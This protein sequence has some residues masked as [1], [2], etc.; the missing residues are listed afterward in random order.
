M[1]KIAIYGFLSFVFCFSVKGQVPSDY[2]VGTWYGFKN[3]AVSYTFDDYT[4]NQL[5]VAMSLFDKYGFKMTFFPIISWNPDWQKLN[6]AAKNGHEV[7]SHTVTHPNLAEI[8][9]TAV[10]RHEIQGSQRFINEKVSAQ[11]CL[12]IAYP[13]CAANTDVKN[14]V[15]E[16]Y[17]GARI[18]S[19]QIEPATPADFMAVSSIS[20]GELGL[21]TAQT[22]NDKTDEAALKN[23]WCVFLFHGVNHDGGYSPIEESVLNEHLNHVKTLDYWVATFG[24]VIKY[25]KERDAIKISELQKTKTKIVMTASVGSLN[26]DIYNV[27]VSVKRLLPPGWKNVKITTHDQVVVSTIE[28]RNGKMYVCFDVVPDGQ[29][30]VITKK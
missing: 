1:K 13:Y 17:I 7:G 8:T 10:C 21:N 30:L 24:H 27:P 29:E 11:H 12:T 26:S 5:P 3:A 22:L 2:Q 23:G 19:G 18:C 15:A 16:T 28:K 4:P 14:M 9:D 20:C 6:D 25:I